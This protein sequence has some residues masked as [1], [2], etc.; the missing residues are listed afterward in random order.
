[1]DRPD[2]PTRDELHADSRPRGDRSQV[3]DELGQVFD[4]VDVVVRRRAD[5]RLARLGATKR[6]DVGRRLATGQLT[7]LAGLRALGDLDL[8]LV[9]AGEVGRRHPE[10]AGRDLLDA[11]IEALAVRA[12]RVPRGILATLPGVRGAAGPLHPDRHGTV[13][14]R[15][16]RTDT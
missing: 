2:A 3:G 7:S 8:E 15:A 1:G 4:R 10:S 9:G 6:G 14:L 11:G 16:Q 13:G 12:R 5:E